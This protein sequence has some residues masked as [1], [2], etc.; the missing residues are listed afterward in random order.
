MLELPA[1]GRPM[2]L[3]ML[4]DCRNDTLIPGFTLWD[5]EVLKNDRDVRNQQGT[6]F[7]V[8][9]SDSINDK[10]SALSIEASLKASF[11]GGL[12]EVSG[13]ADYINDK[14]TT[15]RQSRITL[16][17][18]TTTRYLK[19]DESNQHVDGHVHAI[20]KKI[21]S[22]SIKSEGDMTLTEIEKE[23]VDKLQC[24]FYGDFAPKSNPASYEEAV[25]MYTQLPSMLGDNGELAVPLMVW[26]H[27]LSKLDSK[28]AKLFREIS[29]NIIGQVHDILEGFDQWKTRCDDMVKNNLCTDF[30]KFTEKLNIFK[31]LLIEFKQGFQQKI[32]R[33]LPQVRGGDAVEQVL[34]DIVS[35]CLKSPFNS[36]LVEHW[37][38][39]REKEMNIVKT[40]MK[41][42]A[43]IRVI[44][45]REDLDELLLD[46]SVE[47]V[48]AFSFSS[49]GKED[50]YLK[51]LTRFIWTQTAESYS[52]QKEW[53][54]NVA[55]SKNM[56]MKAKQFN[57]F[58]NV[59][60]AS[61]NTVFV[62]MGFNDGEES[63]AEGGSL[64]HYEH[65][66]LTTK[67]F[68]PPGVPGKPEIPKICHD[69]AMIKWAAPQSGLSCIQCYHVKY[70]ETSPTQDPIWREFRTDA[71]ATL[72]TVPNLKA[73]TTYEFSVAAICEVGHSQL[74]AV[75]EVAT[76]LPTSPP[77]NV[78]K[79]QMSEVSITVVWN[80][81]DVIG[82]GVNVIRYRVSY[83]PSA[84]TDPDHILLNETDG[85]VCLCTL[86]DLDPGTTY[87]VSVSALCGTANDSAFSKPVEIT[88]V[89]AVNQR[90]RNFRE[91]IEKCHTLKI[92]DHSKGEPSLYKLPLT[93]GR[94]GARSKYQTYYIG[95]MKNEA[96]RHFVAMV[97]GATGAGKST[98]I[99]GMINYIF[100]VEWNDDFRFKIIA[101]E[102]ENKA[103]GQAQSQTQ[104]IT[105]YTINPTKWSHLDFRLT[106]IDTPGFG[107]TRGIARDKA[108]VDQIRDFFSDS[109]LHHVD[110]ID[111]IGFVTQASQA[112]LTHTQ[113]YVFDSVLA[114]FGKDIEQNIMLLVTFADGQKPPVIDAIKAA[115]IPCSNNMFKFNNSALFANKSDVD[116]CSAGKSSYD[117]GSNVDNME[118][119]MDDCFDKMFWKMGVQSMRRFFFALSQIEPKSLSLTQEVL[120]ERQR[121][122]V[123]VEGLQPQIQ[124]GCGKLDELQEE[125]R[126][127][128]QHEAEIEAN[129]EFVYDVEVQK[130]EKIDI[131][132]EY[133]TN[134]SRCHFTCHYPCYIGDDSK[135]FNCA[136]MAENGTCI[137]CPGKCVWKVHFN[138]AYRFEYYTEKETRT[139]ADL[140]SRYNDATGKKLTVEQVVKKHQEEFVSVQECV[141]RLITDSH[142][143]L[144]RL[145][146]IALRPNPLSTLD[147]VDI[148][149]EAEQL[150]AKPGWKNRVKSLQ[151]VR[152]GAEIM[153]KIKQA[154]YNPFQHYQQ[155][156]GVKGK[157]KKGVFATFCEFVSGPFRS[158][159]GGHTGV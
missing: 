30:P 62:I 144:K 7:N 32:A 133:I 68:E 109:S 83:V 79:N 9:T 34:I 149:I 17:Y 67:D 55:M 114:I 117:V 27:P 52:P 99:N 120:T 110:H 89:S 139:Y 65:G 97:L 50:E 29:V 39:C 136:A 140:E 121:L 147:Y 108:I 61:E 2:Q 49:L 21:P 118:E 102:G 64:F 134:C 42:L 13:A 35:D 135:K 116:Q 18:K 58:A 80:K 119:G 60:S 53:F 152:K 36:R 47:H 8:I 15:S 41:G 94:H 95:R 137:S 24:K 148:L 59:N 81:P 74:G 56:R 101:E 46:L 142:R 31:K 104:M 130:S 86:E 131:T 122:E 33:A 107:D 158:G 85:D 146:E 88:S 37:L 141:Y 132:G 125:Q 123:A 66:V 143:S 150:E 12:V 106:I 5:P 76:T 113:R 10:S 20:I 72:A 25:F 14:K 54:D 129:K 77:Y 11:M 100:G 16:Q 4:Y 145:E 91:L 159:S 155:H 43:S 45:S 103:G 124:M 112:R 98:L 151:D 48:V 63:T 23:E 40:F 93:K 82:K 90:M 57:E 22:I 153:S 105:S 71:T 73:N 1:L 28:A 156:F 51:A 154:N 138:Q 70:R 44:K 84:D 92:G 157:K 69:S 75:S 87:K 78:R 3:G 96:K 115:K 38:K 111:A 127:L 26:L 128:E 126:I 6:H 19:N